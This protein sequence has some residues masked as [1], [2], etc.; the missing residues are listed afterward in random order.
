MG[1][2]LCSLIKLQ[3][4]EQKLRGTNAILK[5][6]L[7]AVGQQEQNLNQLRMALSAK[8]EEIKLTDDQKAKYE[9]LVTKQSENRSSFDFSGLREMSED[10]RR[11]AME[12]FAADRAARSKQSD[13]E[14]K[15]ILA[16]IREVYRI[17]AEDLREIRKT[18]ADP[19]RTEIL[20]A[21]SDIDIEDMIVEEDMVVTVSHEGYIK[22]NAVSLYRQQRRGGRGKMGAKNKGEDFVADMFVAS[23]HSYILFFTNRG[24]VYWKKV[25]QLPQAG[26]MARGS[27]V[28]MPSAPSTSRRSASATSLIVQ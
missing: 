22:R 28:M 8:Q 16:D 13:E 20:D 27:S 25:H 15:K 6:T 10:E 12:K 5:R 26:R 9:A 23:T 17:I 4:I 3:R 7:R 21:T 14:L 19:R 2:I 1:P 11:A 24:K 18:Y